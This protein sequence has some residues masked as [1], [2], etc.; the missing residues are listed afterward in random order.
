MQMKQSYAKADIGAE[1]YPFIDDM[2]TQY[3]WADLVICRAGATTIAE[4]TSM[5][6]PAIF[7]P[8]PFAADDHQVFNAESL[9]AS[10]GAEMIL[11]KD[12]T[13]DVLS[14]RISH[15]AAAPGELKT[16]A[17]RTKKLGRPDA[18]KRIVDDCYQLFGNSNG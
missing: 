11:Q 3:K 9:V 4:I 14:K 13:P 18:A 8:F 2:A 17:K 16:M 6:R 7:I 10:G 12:L 5:G 1:V 15:Y